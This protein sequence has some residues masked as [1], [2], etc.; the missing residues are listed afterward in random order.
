MARSWSGR[1]SRVAP[2]SHRANDARQR[3]RRRRGRSEDLGAARSS[4]S[5]R[6]GT[7]GGPRRS[8]E[9]RSTGTSSKVSLA[10]TD[11]R[12]SLARTAARSRVL[13]R[14]AVP[15][16]TR[17]VPPVG[18]RPLVALVGSSSCETTHDDRLRRSSSRRA[19]SSPQ[20][21]EASDE[22]T[23]ATGV[24][25]WATEFCTAVTHLDRLAQDDRR[26]AEGYPSS[27]N[28]DS[29]KTPPTTSAR[30]PTPSSTT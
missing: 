4:S 21:A 10:L 5:P 20:D 27:L 22:S 16:G 3:R 2:G 6:A 26:R 29:L 7:A 23:S 9:L 18:S 19:R 1:A 8:F 25:E 12:A 17:A 13:A 15:A 11:E 28:E 24:D 14:R 30:P